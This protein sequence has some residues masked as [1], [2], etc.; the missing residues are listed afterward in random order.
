MLARKF[1]KSFSDICADFMFCVEVAVAI[2]LLVRLCFAFCLVV[3]L[4]FWVRLVVGGGVFFH[5]SV[6]RIVG[7]CWLWMWVHVECLLGSTGQVDPFFS[8]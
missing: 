3:C 8:F 6:M 4:R 7:F 2:L 5:L 1:L